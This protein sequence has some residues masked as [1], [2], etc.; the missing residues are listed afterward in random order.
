MNLRPLLPVPWIFLKAL[1]KFEGMAVGVSAVLGTAVFLFWYA[2]L[3]LISLFASPAW[4]DAHLKM[5]KTVFFVG[6]LRTFSLCLAIGALGAVAETYETSRKLRGKGESPAV[7]RA[8]MLAALK[9]VAEEN[10]KE[11]GRTGDSP[12]SSNGPGRIGK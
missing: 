11:A 3:W 12:G 9:D 6:G 7:Y 10:A 8:V 5:L 4:Y 2:F 1:L